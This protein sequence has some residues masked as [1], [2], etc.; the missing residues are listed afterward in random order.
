VNLISPRIEYVGGGKARLEMKPFG[1]DPSVGQELYNFIKS[2]KLKG[3]PK[4]SKDPIRLE[5]KNLVYRE[6]H[7]FKI[8][9]GTLDVNDLDPWDQ[10]HIFYTLRVILITKGYENVDKSRQYITSQIKGVC[11]EIGLEVRGKGFKRHELG[12]NAAER[13]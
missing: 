10:S 6:R 8:A 4:N 5:L 9:N 13:A 12:I 7:P 3:K 1:S 2:P 11:W